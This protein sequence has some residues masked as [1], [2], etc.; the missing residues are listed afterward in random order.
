[1]PRVSKR[2]LPF[3]FLTKILHAF[4]VSP[5]HATCPTHLLP[6]DLVTII[7]FG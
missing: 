5:M 2:F 6:I 4:L 3:S 7:I 1:M